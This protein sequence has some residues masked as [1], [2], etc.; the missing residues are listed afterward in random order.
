MNIYICN[1]FKIVNLLDDM[2][3]KLKLLAKND[4]VFVM[5]LPSLD[6]I[7]FITYFPL[8]GKR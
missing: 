8:N 6:V 2:Y 7:I 1:E 5:F 4:C 3:N